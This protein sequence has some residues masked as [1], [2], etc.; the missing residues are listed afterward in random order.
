MTFTRLGRS[1]LKVSDVGLGTW[2]FGYPETGDGARS[3]EKTSLAILD[4]AAELGLVFWDTADRY[5][6]GTG[7]SEKIIGKWLKANPNER[8][9]VVLATKCRVIMGGETPNHEGLSRRHIVEAV[10]NSLKR[11]QQDHIDLLQFHAPDLDCPI[12]ETVRAID[13]LIRQGLVQYWGVSNFNVAQLADFQEVADRYLC[14]RLISVQNFCN[15][16]QG[17]RPQQTGVLDYCA[18]HGIGHIPFSPLAKGLASSRYIDA[19]KVGPGDRLYDDG[20]LDKV[21]T[22]K[23]LAIV[24]VLQDLAKQHNKTVAQIA[25]AW[26]LTHPGVA[27]VIPSCSTPEQV[28]ENAGAS[29]LRLSDGEMSRIAE[30][31]T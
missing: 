19:A 27:T 29:G 2:K 9:N 22:D 10:H 13:D 6:A 16:I 24:K 31:R 25:L 3:D 23:A 14:C 11:L 5:N 17:E 1:G 12:E 7:N 30:A 26:L 21:R 28:V 18:T 4:K 20:N 15:V 8:T